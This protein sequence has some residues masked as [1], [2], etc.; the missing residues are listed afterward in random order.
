M[1]RQHSQV[2]LKTCLEQVLREQADG[3][4]H[5]ARA[6]RI[7]DLPACKICRETVRKRDVLT[8]K[9]RVLTYK[10]RVLVYTRLV[11]VYTPRE[12]IN[13]R[14]ELINKRLVLVNKRR[15]ITVSRA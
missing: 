12:T 11:L 2:H 6:S 4:K 7:T 13:T 8:Y 5:C 3:Q 9:R 14:H 15:E 10:R 1:V